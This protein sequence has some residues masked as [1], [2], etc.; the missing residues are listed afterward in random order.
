MELNISSMV[1][2]PSTASGKQ[3]KEPKSGVV[4]SRPGQSLNLH[5]AD[6]KTN[7][8]MILKPPGL[9]A[10]DYPNNAKPGLSWMHVQR[11]RTVLTLEQIWPKT[12]PTP[13]GPNLKAF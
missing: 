8:V 10:V 11:V 13:N 7:D 3:D 6:L 9:T 5:G 2:E 1:R 4:K 12:M